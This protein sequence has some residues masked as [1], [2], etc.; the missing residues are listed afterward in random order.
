MRLPNVFTAMADIAMGFLITHASFEPLGVFTLLLISSSCLYTAGMV[1][2]DVYDVEIDRGERP[3]RPLPSGIIP[4]NNAWRLGWSLL[5]VGILFGWAA[6]AVTFNLVPGAFAT[7]LAGIIV[8]YDRDRVAKKIG[9]TRPLLMGGC[10]ALNVLLGMSAAEQWIDIQPYIAIGLG[11]YIFG[12]TW[13]SRSEAT[14]SK[15]LHLTGALLTI[16][17]GMAVLWYYPQF[18]P[19]EKLQPMLQLQP[20]NWTV[21]WAMLACIIGW[22]ALRAILQPDPAHVQATVKTGILSIIVLDAVVVLAV[23]GPVAS[24]AILLL[25]IPTIALG[26]WVYS[27]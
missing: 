16:L 6:T 22:R 1:L 8:I 7:F 23:H 12:I 14:T 21:L 3:N 10:R 24:I 4:Y 25:L 9:P 5:A 2:N 18:M 27:T 17:A 26:W 19:P 11:I 13:F 20:Q 15:R